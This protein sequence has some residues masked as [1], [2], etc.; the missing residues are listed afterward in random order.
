ME[1]HWHNG[2]ICDLLSR[3]LHQQ[4]AS[5]DRGDTKMPWWYVPMCIGFDVPI[6][7]YVLLRF[8]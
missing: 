6:G 3:S 5:P 1:G 7:L 2:S 4:D 8:G